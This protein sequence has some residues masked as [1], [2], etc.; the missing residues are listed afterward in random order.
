MDHLGDYE[1]GPY[2]SIHAYG[3]HI[4]KLFCRE[5]SLHFF[6]FFSNFH[7]SY[8]FL[9]FWKILFNSYLN[10]KKSKQNTI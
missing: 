1:W 6:I 3:L 2:T 4:L 8:L 9:K 5:E 7:F 10:Q